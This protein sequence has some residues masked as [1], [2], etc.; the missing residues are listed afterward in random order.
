VS[1]QYPEF[2]NEGNE[3][4]QMHTPSILAWTSFFLVEAIGVCL[5]SMPCGAI[6]ARGEK[7]GLGFWKTFLVSFFLTPLAGMTMILMARAANLNRTSAES[8]SHR[9]AAASLRVSS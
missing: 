4:K 7:D 3:E 2:T 6:A 5:W 1:E 8:A 9:P